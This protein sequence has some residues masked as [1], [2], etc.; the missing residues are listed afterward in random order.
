LKVYVG[1][2]HR[3]VAFKA[4]IVA[5]LGDMDYDVIDI[6]THDPNKPCD[7]PEIGHKVAS[8]VAANRNSRG[9][10]LCMSGIGQTI[11]ANKVK[12]AYAALC[13]DAKTAALS[14]QHNNANIL[15][16]GAM[17][18]KQRELKKLVS[19]WLTTEFEGGRHLR[20][21]NKIKKIEAKAC[22]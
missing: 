6:G 11:V 1:A 21:V 13:H 4:K 12:G 7:Y 14:R 22:A 18:L 20:R 5:I 17:S 2:D 16:L 8:L 15:V 9:I 10:L 3:G 19:T